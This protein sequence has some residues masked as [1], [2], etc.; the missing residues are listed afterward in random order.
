MKI[1][2]DTTK[3]KKLA[4]QYF[5]GT[6]SDTDEITLFEYINQNVY[7]G[8]E[9]R[10][11]EK[12]WA[13]KAAVNEQTTKEWIS[14]ERQLRIRKSISMPTEN[15]IH[16]KWKQ[17]IA[18]AAI[19]IVLLGSS[20]GLWFKVSSN[21]PDNYFVCQA[22]YGNKTKI[23]LPDGTSVWLNAGS[24][25]KYSN[26][27]NSKNRLVE[28]NGEGYFEVSKHNGVTFTV[29]TKG[30]NVVVKGTKFD[31]SAYS[32][33][34]YIMTSL[35][36]GRV[37]IHYKQIK[38]NI[39]PGQAAMLNLKTKQLSCHKM[40]V[41]QSKSWVENRI[42]FDDITVKEL[43]KKLSRQYAVNILL[44]SEK[45]GAMK[46]CISLRNKET[47]DEVMDGL[48]KIIPITVVH[49]GKDIYIK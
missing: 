10:L 31:V 8:N 46:L 25:I 41:N 5:S 22:P 6:I 18:V 27:F 14:L 1:M 37:E 24:T 15:I 17:M 11:W 23:L 19:F 3:I 32:D 28:L 33:D 30:Y 4:F 42:D 49:K 45:V 43:S 39:L 21:V 13:T 44:E 29:H 35:L 48:K 9:F 47:I 16:R 2:E 20:F 34:P 12:E 26:K 7:N 36:E 40:N 38:M